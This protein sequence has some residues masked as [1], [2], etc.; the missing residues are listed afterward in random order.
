[1][2]KFIRYELHPL[3]WEFNI[4]ETRAAAVIQSCFR[5]YKARKLYNLKS[6]RKV[7]LPTCVGTGYCSA[8]GTLDSGTLRRY[9]YSS[10]HQAVELASHS[11]TKH[12]S[13]TQYTEYEIDSIR[14]EH[15]YTA[16]S[17][18]SP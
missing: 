14:G 16:R 6:L 17:I 15:N 2:R 3:L 5:G 13:R 7:C 4:D 9:D 12:L 8:C 10:Y 18:T 11:S 1:M